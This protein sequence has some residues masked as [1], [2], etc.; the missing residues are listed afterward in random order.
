MTKNLVLGP[1][2]A[3]ILASKRFFVD[4]TSTRFFVSDYN[5]MEFQGKLINQTGENSK[6]SSFRFEFGPNSGRQGFFFKNLAL[7][8][9]RYHGQPSSCIRKRV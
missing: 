3:Q 9:T 6:K 5:C 4:F 7:S 2:L 1:I 8:V